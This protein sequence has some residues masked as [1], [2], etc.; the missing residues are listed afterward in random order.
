MEGAD[1]CW[2]Y[3]VPVDVGDKTADLIER[4]VTPSATQDGYYISVGIVASSIQSTPVDMVK[5][6]WASGVSNVNGTTLEI[7]Q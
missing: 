7:K 5:K 4:Y 1:G 6:Q 3:T 2:Y